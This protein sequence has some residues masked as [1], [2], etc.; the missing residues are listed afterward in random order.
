MSGSSTRLAAGIALSLLTACNGTDDGE[1]PTDPTGAAF[2]HAPPG[3]LV[4]G[5]GEGVTDNTVYAPGIRFPIE[6]APAYANSQVH[7]AGGLHGP[8]GGQ[9]DESNY[10]YP[11]RDNFCET[12]SWTAP[13]CPA[14]SGHQGQD[15]RPKTCEK[16]KHWAVATENGRITNIG[17]YTVTLQGDSGTQY[18][19][20]HMDM[21]ALAVDFGDTVTKGQRLGLISNDFGGTPTTIHLHFDMKQNVEVN[22]DVVFTFVPPYPSL[23][24]SYERLLRGG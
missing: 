22:G 21:D 12:R 8:P 2:E 20:M 15:I 9:C 13:L 18:R 23:V 10:S 17:I 5:S 11:W 1:P 19:Y 14:G 24:D 16:A 4:S 3:E 6:E 7:G